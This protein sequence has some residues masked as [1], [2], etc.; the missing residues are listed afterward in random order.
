[1][2]DYFYEALV[3]ELS[4]TAEIVQTAGPGV[5]RVRIALVDIM[6]TSV[7]KSVVGTVAPY[8]FAV[9]LTSGVASGRP[10]GSTPYLGETGIEV[11]F[12]DGDTNEI[13]GEYADNQV[14]RKYVVE[15]EE[16]AVG[17]AKKWA[18]GYFNSFEA[19]GYAKGAFDYWAALFRERFDQLRK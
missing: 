13:I 15:L 7:S 9:E 2:L 11:Q 18:D 12:L 14:G 1:M 8:A 5:I 17:A 4:P 19:W 3:R 10:V 6:P 16:G